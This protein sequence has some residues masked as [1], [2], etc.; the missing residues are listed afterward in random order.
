MNSKERMFRA[1]R[2]ER[3][4]RVPVAPCY[5]LLYL[6]DFIGRYYLEQYRRRVGKQDRYSLDHEEDTQFRANALYQALGIFEETVDWFPV[7]R[8]GSSYAWARDHCIE[9]VDEEYFFVNLDNGRRL[10]FRDALLMGTS[11]ELGDLTREW[12]AGLDDETQDL[13]DLSGEIESLRDVELATPIVSTDHLASQGLFD[14]PRQLVKDYGERRFLYTNALS[15]FDGV[16]DLLGFAGMMMSIYDRPEMLHAIMERKLAQSV[17]V[18]RGLAELG[19][20]GVWLIQTLASADLISRR[21][22]VEFGLG[23]TQALVDEIKS[24]GMA[25]IL[26]FC[27]DA[28]PRLDLIRDLGVD[29]VALEESK[30][31]FR[32]DIEEVVERVGD[33]ACVF[34]NIDAVGVMEQGSPEVIEQEV[35]RQISAGKRARGFVLGIGSPLPRTT[36]PRH[37][38]ALVRAAKRHGQ[39]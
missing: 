4:D 26:Y 6:E 18:L 21:H 20:H 8:M 9:R 22:F 27:G 33:V 13:W 34:G 3:P 25:T 11:P 2:G 5:L 30:K 24:M 38:D 36:N 37:I 32:I 7:L 28:V 17:E 19:V 23:P 31:T 12:V 29:A 1:L 16:Y 10:S 14:L 35:K 39:L 15:P